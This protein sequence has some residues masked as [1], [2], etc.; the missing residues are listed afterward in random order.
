VG[1]R[2]LYHHRTQALDGQRVHINAIQRALREQGHEVI[3]IAPLPAVEAAGGQTRRT[4]KRVALEALA[5]AAPRGGYEALELSYNLVGYMALSAA[6]R[7]VNPHFIYERY[8]LNTTAGAWASARHGV[9]LLLEVNSPL[10]DEKRALGQLLFHRTSQRIERYVLRAAARVLAVTDVLA[11]MLRRSAQLASDR[12]LVVQNGADAPSIAAAGDASA[13]K[14]EF[15]WGPDDVVL[16][17]VG[18]FRE[19]HGVDALLQA[20][21][22]L[23]S[24]RLTRVLLVGEGPA[25]PHLRE[26]AATLDLTPNVAFTGAVPHDR[27]PRYLAAMDA[28]VIPRAVEYASPLKLF[29][30]MAAGKAIIAPRQPN[31]LE[32]L[33]EDVDALCFERENLPELVGAVRRVVSDRSLRQRLGAEAQ[34]TI[35]REDLTWSGNARRI[36]AAFESLRGSKEAGRG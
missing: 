2:I 25:L 11:G 8:A 15:G 33:T 22:S 13:L 26:L 3:E 12:V 35:A 7:R 10:A 6:I 5:R 32:V 31:L 24:R 18:F 20:V 36:V 14:A 29:E 17:S 1:Y 27:I 23:D 19:W 21:A 30:Y 4:W 34:R 16:G 9:P 28:V